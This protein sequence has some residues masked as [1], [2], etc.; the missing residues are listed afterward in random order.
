MRRGCLGRLA[1]ATIP[2]VAPEES[3]TISFGIDTPDYIF[4]CS[5]HESLGHI[6]AMTVEPA[7]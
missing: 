6:G 1:A 5:F 3:R 7:P 4:S 2:V